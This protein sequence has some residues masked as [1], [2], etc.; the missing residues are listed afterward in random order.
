MYMLAQGFH[1]LAKDRIVHEFVEILF[2]VPAG[3][4]V[5]LCVHPNV[6]LHPGDLVEL[7]S[8]VDFLKPH[9]QGE[10]ELKVA[11][12]Q[13]ILGLVEEVRHQLY[14]FDFHPPSSCWYSDIHFF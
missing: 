7:Q 3:L 11:V 10:I 9:T 12:V 14:Y 8:S 5:K 2:K 1:C 6:G 4:L 13:H